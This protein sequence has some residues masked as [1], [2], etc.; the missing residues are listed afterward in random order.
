MNV[1]EAFSRDVQG[2]IQD[3]LG[4]AN[5]LYRPR[6]VAEVRR[7]AAR[8]IWAFSLSIFWSEVKGRFADRGRNLVVCK[9][10]GEMFEKLGI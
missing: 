1:S 2:P 5:A 4:A 10:A 8:V 3:Q 9:D 7:N 6:L